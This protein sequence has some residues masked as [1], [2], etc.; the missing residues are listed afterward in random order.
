MKKATALVSAI[1]AIVMLVGALG[2]GFS[3]KQVRIHFAEKAAGAKSAPKAEQSGEKAAGPV[4]GETDRS[5]EPTAEQRA[6]R[7]GERPGMRDGRENMSEEE[8]RQLM[9]ER[10]NRPDA[11]RQGDGGRRT[12]GM[13]EE[14]RQAMRERFENMSEEERARFR[15]EMRGRSGGRQR[16]DRGGMP[17]GSPDGRIRGGDAGESATD[18]NQDADGM[19]QPQSL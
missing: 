4:G 11:G 8:R 15:E 16:S 5:A 17:G 3:V 7:Q 12:G 10:G 2:I 18:A 19:A 6:A 9:A 1:I 14:E 13:S